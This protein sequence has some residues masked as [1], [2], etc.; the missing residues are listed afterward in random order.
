M[1]GGVE[2]TG[3]EAEDQMMLVYEIV[4]RRNLMLTA[5]YGEGNVMPLTEFF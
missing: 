5:A 4:L 3:A 2:Q 1:R